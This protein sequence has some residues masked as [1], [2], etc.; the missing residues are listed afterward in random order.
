MTFRCV[1]MMVQLN[2]C[3]APNGYSLLVVGVPQWGGGGTVG[4]NTVQIVST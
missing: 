4:G 1:F 3:V 2:K